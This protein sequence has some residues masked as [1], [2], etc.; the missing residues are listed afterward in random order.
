MPLV[1]PIGSAH[2]ALHLAF[3]GDPEQMI[4]T[5]GVNI[6]STPSPSDLAALATLFHTSFDDQLVDEM[7]LVAAKATVGTSGDPIIVETVLDLQFSAAGNP[8]IPNTAVLL[9]KVTGLGGRH[10]RGRMYVPGY[11]AESVFSYGVIDPT[12]LLALQGAADAFL[13]GIP[14]AT[15]PWIE[16]VLLHTDTAPSTT[17]TEVTQLVAQARLASQ[18]RRLRP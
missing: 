9:K 5:F 13:A 1:I 6:E 12:N 11:R 8:L 4:T 18:R 7:T 3:S 16:M 2:V 17:P 15:G 14:G 10:Q